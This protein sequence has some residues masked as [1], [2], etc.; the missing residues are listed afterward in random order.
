MLAR[1]R[2]LLQP[3]RYRMEKLHELLTRNREEQRHMLADLGCLRSITVPPDPPS[4]TVGSGY[5][6]LFEDRATVSDA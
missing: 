4:G 1:N 6:S 2:R 3:S 5:A